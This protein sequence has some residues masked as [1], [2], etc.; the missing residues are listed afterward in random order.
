[1]RPSRYCVRSELVLT[2]RRRELAD[3][4]FGRA[5]AEHHVGS[6]GWAGVILPPAPPGPFRPRAA[7]PPEANVRGHLF[8]GTR[9]IRGRPPSH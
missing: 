3:V 1:V 6:R 5:D 9:V 8:A 4:A 7:R 2:D